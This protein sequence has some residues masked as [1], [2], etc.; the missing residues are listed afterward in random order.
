M[1]G[2]DKFN[3]DLVE[4][5][6]RRGWDV[7]IAATQDNPAWLPHFTRWTPDVFALP[8]F[9][10]PADYPRFLLYLLRSRQADL[11]LLSHSEL[12][13]HLLP[14]LRAHAPEVPF[15]DYLHV[16]EESWH[17]G[18]YPRLSVQYRSCL[19]LSMVSSQHLEQW[20]VAE[21]A[22]PDRL[23]VC[24]TGGRVVPDDG[25]R[26]AREQVRDELGVGA[27]ERLILY[28]ARLCAQKQP[29]VF[30]ATMQ[31]LADQ[32]AAFH[33]IVAGDGPDR[34]WL[35]AFLKRHRLT[36]RVRLLGPVPPERVGDLM[37]AAD[38]CF[39]PSTH[40]G[41]ALTLYEAMSHGCVFVGADVGGQAEVATEPFAV[42]LPRQRDEEREAAAY[43]VAISQLLHDPDAMRGTGEAARRRIAERFSVEQMAA[44]MEQAFAMAERLHREK[45]RPALTSEIATLM[46]TRAIEYDRVAAVAEELWSREAGM[47]PLYG[48]GW[49]LW[50]FRMCTHLEPAYAW[51]VR[52]GWRWLPTAR[53][54]IRASLAS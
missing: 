19:D 15:V 9:L 51:G 44:T 31:L 18:G 30:A 22:E 3:L 38:I 8:A 11:V 12:A 33:C 23:R 32:G 46:A 42:L 40:E 1:G 50:V 20:M 13:Y 29:R 17:S 35:G 28:P 53:E 24:Y 49:R 6:V 54:W 2:S 52:R 37:A 36:E 41:V 21:G 48:G 16:I 39:L 26:R 34:A 25:L 45:P 43:A 4:M 10:R 14:F 7:T 5:L 47:P 27:A